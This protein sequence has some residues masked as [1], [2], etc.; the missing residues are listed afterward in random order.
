LLPGADA[1]RTA[2]EGEFFIHCELNM[3]EQ[4]NISSGEFSK[5]VWETP[6]I[7]EL[8]MEETQGLL[9]TALFGKME[10]PATG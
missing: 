4:E 5:S 2:A 6:S 1:G 10:L 3:K 9:P 7:F 8:P